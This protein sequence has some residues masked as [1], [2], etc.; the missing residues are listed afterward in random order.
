MP[1][2]E[3]MGLL[4]FVG[5]EL[6]AEDVI[7]AARSLGRE[8]DHGEAQEFI[9]TADKDELSA[10]SRAAIE[11]ANEFEARTAIAHARLADMLGRHFAAPSPF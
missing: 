6:I 2:T 10:I 9:D 5:F 7:A 1:K 3:F 8:M 4:G 11:G